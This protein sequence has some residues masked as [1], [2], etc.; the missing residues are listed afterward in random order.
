MAGGGLT[1]GFSQDAFDPFLLPDYTREFIQQRDIDEFA[2]ALNAPEAAP[3]VAL[4]DWKP[5]HQRV[6]KTRSRTFRRKK[7]KRST[8]ETRE[9]FVYNV[10][11]WPFLFIVLGWI[12]ALCVSYLVTRL[13]IW[14]Y[15]RLVTWRGPRQILRR[16]L[17][18]KSDF[19][20]WKSAAEELDAYLGNEKWKSSDEYAYYDHSTVERVKDQLK[21]TRLQAQK[22]DTSSAVD[23]TDRLR[24]LVE[25]C[26]KNNAFGVENPRLYSET[27]YG[28]KH[29]AQ[30]FLDELHASLQFLLQDSKLSRADKYA[31][32]KHLHRNYGRCALLLSGGATLSYYHFGVVKALADHSLLPDVITGTS[33]GALV[34]ALVSTRTDQEL[35]ALLVPALAHRIKA[36]AD[37]FMTWGPRWWRTG[38]RLRTDIPLKALNLHFNVNFS[39]VSQVNPHVNLF[40][41]A[42]RGTVGRPVTHRKGRGWRGGFLGSA[43]ETSIKLDLAKYLKI[44]KHLE[45]L[46]RPLGQD[47]SGIYLQTFSGTITIWPKSSL[48]DFYYLLSDPSPERLAYMIRA[49]QR[50][51]FPKL[52]FIENRMKVER[53]IEEGLLLA[54]DRFSRNDMGRGDDSPHM[55]GQALRK[56]AESAVQ[57]SSTD[58]L[59][60]LRRESRSSSVL[61]EL[62]RQSGVFFD[63]TEADGDET[64]VSEDAM[65]DGADE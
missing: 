16:N 25:A 9:G 24:A 51:T 3:V 18:S 35:R 45:L 56:S 47:W 7:P 50:S 28:T 26:V 53:L 2:K 40:F 36:C 65:D 29:L 59:P 4:N 15:E 37:G 55:H 44:L 38:A 8:D 22:Q 60:M 30:A 27:Y 11:K 49:G 31:L 13:Y 34:A 32:S 23:A 43:I 57:R 63:D 10:L 48:R 20:E 61:E 6:R 33:G 58:E 52:L 39:I 17:Q 41:F 5:V 54:N 42:S 19:A 14:A 64:D 1:A 12:W 62:R 21:S 46:P